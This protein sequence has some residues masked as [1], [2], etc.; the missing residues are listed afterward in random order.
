MSRRT[1]AA[2]ITAAQAAELNNSLAGFDN[3]VS[4]VFQRA[5]LPSLHVGRDEFETAVARLS[6]NAVCDSSLAVSDDV[7]RIAS[8]AQ[9]CTAKASMSAKAGHLDQ[10]LVT[11]DEAVDLAPESA[12]NFRQRATVLD[13]LGRPREALADLDEAWRIDP[14]DAAT[15]KA[16]ARELGIVRQLPG[17]TE[18]AGLP[19]D[20]WSEASAAPAL[21]GP[22]DAATTPSKR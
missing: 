10:A 11:L 2:E 8:S 20:P 18:P 6:P 12:A 9:A 15:Q 14:L 4:T 17:N 19:F 22:T 7:Q 16:R 1:Y 21:A 5:A 13:Q 3:A